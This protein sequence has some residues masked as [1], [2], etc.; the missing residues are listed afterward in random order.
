MPIPLENIEDSAPLHEET[1]DIGA[2]SSPEDT[3]EEPE[4]LEL[5]EIRVFKCKLMAYKKS[6]PGK[7]SDLNWSALDG[8]NIE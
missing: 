2:V 7:F 3:P 6:F 5:A 1:F 4:L 8:N